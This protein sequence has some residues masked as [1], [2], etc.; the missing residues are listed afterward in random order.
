MR[1]DPSD[2]GGVLDHDGDDERASTRV[3]AVA[4]D[5]APEELPPLSDVVDPGALDALFDARTRAECPLS[6]SY[7]NTD[8]FLAGTG[9]L[10]VQPADD[11]RVDA[12]G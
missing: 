11:S 1:D 7:A 3:V 5:T 4:T 12:D 6:F 9:E 10:P 2:Y 8:V